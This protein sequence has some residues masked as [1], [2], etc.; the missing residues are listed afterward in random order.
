[1]TQT[2]VKEEL[3]TLIDAL[4][5]DQA[6][7]VLDFAVLL[8]QRQGSHET[9]AK[10]QEGAPLSEWEAALVK[11]EKYWFQLPENVRAQY[12]GRIVALSHNRILD[13]DLELKVLRKRITEQYPDQPILYLE[14]DAEQEP[15]LVIRSPRLR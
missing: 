9:Q 12:A 14:T 3:N 11:A 8:R 4:P 15:V 1:M 5:P 13:T 7:L 2:Q 10:T 6:E